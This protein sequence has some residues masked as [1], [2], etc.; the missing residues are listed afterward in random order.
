MWRGP[1]RISRYPRLPRWIVPAAW[2][3]TIRRVSYPKSGAPAIPVRVPIRRACIGK[4]P[5][6]HVTAPRRDIQHLRIRQGSAKPVPCRSPRRAVQRRTSSPAR[7]RPPRPGAGQNRVRPGTARARRTRMPARRAGRTVARTMQRVAVIAIAVGESA[8]QR[9]AVATKTG[10]VAQ[11]SV[12]RPAGAFSNSP[13]TIFVERADEAG[14]RGGDKR[15]L[16][17]EL[18]QADRL[19]PVPAEML[20]AL[21]GHPCQ[22][23]NT[24]SRGSGWLSTSREIRRWPCGTL[25]I[26]RPGAAGKGAISGP[27]SAAVK[28]VKDRGMQSAKWPSPGAGLRARSPAAWRSMLRG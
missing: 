2:Q 27:A 17:L 19:D 25:P 11:Q 10:N 23:R 28:R 26:F 13:P 24:C 14:E 15:G 1:V 12:R 5:G 21:L 4:S 8:G 20:D 9:T 16:R 18:W 3:T 22:S 6:Q 7:D